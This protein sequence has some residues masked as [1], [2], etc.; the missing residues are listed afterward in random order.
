MAG[1][2]MG[3]FG[4]IQHHQHRQ[5][6]AAIT[7][8]FSKKTVHS[9]E[10]LI[11]GHVEE[12]CQ[13]IEKQCAMHGLT[14]LRAT[15]LAYSTD[16]VCDYFFGKPVGLLE[17]EVAAVEWKETIEAL[18]FFTP[19]AKQLTWLIPTAKRLPVPLVAIF[20]RALAQAVDIFNVS[21]ILRE[22]NWKLTPIPG[23]E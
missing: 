23:Y 15:Y 6:R 13:L 10:A 3:S 12:L 16:V 11:R 2:T 14:E 1:V 19:Y 22:R 5:R 18:A 21:V 4:T 20:S 17:D 7:S 9:Y 8:L